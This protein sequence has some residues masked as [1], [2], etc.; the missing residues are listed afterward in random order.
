MVFG[1]RPP[2]LRDFG[3]AGIFTMIR[4]DKIRANVEG[5]GYIDSCSLAMNYEAPCGGIVG[6]SPSCFTVPG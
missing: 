6:V 3:P 1:I 2:G 4:Y 5:D